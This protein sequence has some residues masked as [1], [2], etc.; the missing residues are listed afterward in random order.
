[1]VLFTELGLSDEI[2]T[3]I[4][5]LGFTEP[6]LIQEKSIPHIMQGKDVIGESATGSGKTLAFGC[7]VIEHVKPGQGLQALVLAPTRELAEQVKTSL[8]KLTKSLKIT[9]VYG[10]V[11]IEPQ[12]HALTQCEVAVCTPGRLLD[13]LQRRTVNLSKVEL[14]VLDE[15][16]R[17]L[18]MGFIDDVEKIMS[19]CPDK[20]QTLFFSATMASQIK[21]LAQRY[22][23]NPVQ[24]AATQQVDPSKLE[25]VYFDIQRNMKLSLL[26]HLL[27]KEDSGLVMVFCNTRRTVDFVVHNLKAN[28]VKAIAIHGGFSQNKRMNTLKQF[29]N[30]Y[31]G[32][33]VCTDVAARGLHIDNVSHVYNYEIPNDSKEY[34]H[35]IG[36]TARAGSEGKVVN[37]ICD[38]DHE[39]FSK[40]LRDYRNFTITKLEKPH[41]ERVMA[42]RVE[43]PQRR[44]GSWGGR[45]GES[46]GSGHKSSH[47]G[48]WGS[49]DGS[50]RG[51]T[52]GGARGRSARGGTARSGPSS[53]QGRRR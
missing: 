5:R 17:M 10:G 35:R 12:I 14:L 42:Q 44:A 23:D 34:V 32:A 37:L 51:R 30:M 3:A 48:T 4:N 53:N 25:Q 28:K 33:L 47:G 24:V 20:R 16:D 43:E 29:D 36:R 6:T 31:E 11:G 18:D 19:Q 41:V 52:R 22:M 50:P 39:G 13:H 40:V 21:S 46:R 45:R 2:L 9:T 38:F 8:Q 49:R 1:M 15:A 26:V 27:K 7:G